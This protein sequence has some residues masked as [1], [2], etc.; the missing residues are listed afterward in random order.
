MCLYLI[1]EVVLVV[2]ASPFHV[3]L[4]G[5]QL[6]FGATISVTAYRNLGWVFPVGFLF[7]QIFLEA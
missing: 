6:R 1:I 4:K 2:S 3:C 7:A 5:G